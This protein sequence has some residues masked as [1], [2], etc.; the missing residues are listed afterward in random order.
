[1][2]HILHILKQLEAL[3]KRKNIISF[4]GIEIQLLKKET[5]SIF[6]D[7]LKDSILPQGLL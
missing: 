7:Y 4:V 6:S 3:F 5:Y 2:K 1:M